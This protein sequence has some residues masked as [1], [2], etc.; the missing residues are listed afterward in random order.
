MNVFIVSV[1]NEQEGTRNAFCRI[2]FFG[3]G[4][5][6]ANLNNDDIISE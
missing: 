6:G 3:G 5:G 4:G 2:F 1:P